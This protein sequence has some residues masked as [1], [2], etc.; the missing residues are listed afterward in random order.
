MKDLSDYIV[1]QDGG[2]HVDVTD[3][4]SGEYLW[5]PGEHFRFSHDGKEYEGLATDRS[6]EDG[7]A[8][9]T[10]REI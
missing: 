9:V 3:V 10:Y 1:R 6:H 2:F 5:E 4:D 7:M 8:E